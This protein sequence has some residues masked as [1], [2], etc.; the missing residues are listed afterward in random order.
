MSEVRKFRWWYRGVDGH[1]TTLA[2]E[3]T[4]WAVDSDEAL[5]NIEAMMRAKFPE[6]RWKHGRAIEGVGENHG[7]QFGPSVRMLKKRMEKV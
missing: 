1:G 6:I 2:F 4:G 7:L 3:G 5:D